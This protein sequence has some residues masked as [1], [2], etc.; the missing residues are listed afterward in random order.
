MMTLEKK[1]KVVRS[2]TRITP[3]Q[4]KFIK[5]LAKTTGH[6]E[7][8]VFREIIQFYIDNHKK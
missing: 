1:E 2:N 5:D 6:S 8:E 4:S 7:G 3:T